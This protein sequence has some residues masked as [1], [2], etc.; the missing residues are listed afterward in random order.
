MYT[1]WCTFFDCLTD[2]KN[3]ISLSNEN[4]ADSSPNYI[5]FNKNFCFSNNKKILGIYI[6]NSYKLLKDIIISTDDNLTIMGTPGMGKSFFGFYLMYFLIQNNINFVYEPSGTDY[7]FLF[8]NG[9]L[10]IYN[11]QLIKHE[12][13]IIYIVDDH[14]PSDLYKSFQ[15]RTILICSPR[16]EYIKKFTKESYKKYFLPIWRI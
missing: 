8:I 10:Q 9:N 5:K 1:F 14:A 13:Q 6:R 16:D 3:D 11:Y 7:R 15:F 4:D 2:S 12:K